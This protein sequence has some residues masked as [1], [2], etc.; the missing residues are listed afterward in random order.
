MKGISPMT[1]SAVPTAQELRER[2]AR[3]QQ[4]LKA[5][6]VAGALLV[7][8]TDRY[9]FTGT[10]QAGFVAIPVEGEPLILVRKD[11]ARAIEES[12]L[13]VETLSSMRQLPELV[14]S[15]WGGMDGPL[16][17]EADV[18]P[19]AQFNRFRSMFKGVELGD[20]SHSIML[21]RANKSDWEV[22]KIRGAALGVKD[23]VA[24]VPKFLREGM[25]GIELAAHVEFEMR[26]RGHAG[27]TPMRAFNQQLHY[28]HVLAGPSGAV[29]GG[30]DMPTVGLGMSPAVGQG[31][32]SRPIA[33]GEAVG[34][35]MV[36]HL[37][38]YLSDQTRMFAVGEIV[39][40]FG[41]AY[42]AAV[43]VMDAVVAAARPGVKA[44]ALYQTA[45][46]VAGDTPFADH[47]MGQQQ[48]VNFV[49]HG[50]GLE[51][52]EYPFLAR[53][54]NMELAQGMVFALEPK[55]IFEG[56]GA[57]G[58]EDTFVVRSDGVEPLTS[59]SREFTVVE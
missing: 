45:L 52:D 36:G 41:Q 8:N 16:A 5:Q 40:P 12:P 13:H 37:D 25:S 1:M 7:Q 51:I 48:K 3:F 17:L 39:E 23:A 18:L 24:Q 44:S 46:D 11:P 43:A 9:Y 14:A 58:I 31:A 59:S 20:C 30:F 10:A 33:R 53:G 34:V 27:F 54:F 26:K 57:V 55:F 50:I 28:G 21:T 2:I 35:D 42:E 29:S 32:S 49:G 15:A 22:E 56:K 6:E 19:V 4:H 38:G 47:F